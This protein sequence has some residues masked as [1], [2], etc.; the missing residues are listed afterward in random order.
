MQGGADAEKFHRGQRVRFRVAQSCGHFD[1]DPDI[2]AA[3]MPQLLLNPAQ[4]P[5]YL[6]VPTPLRDISGA[7]VG[8]LFILRS[9]AGARQRL[10][11]LRREIVALWLLALVAA[12][13]PPILWR[14]RSCGR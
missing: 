4:I 14:A 11:A 10:A 13:L 5:G 12:L 3:V 1:A 7:P 6:A 2:T 8:Q 9:L